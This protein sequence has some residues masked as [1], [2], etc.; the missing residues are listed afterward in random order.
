V[1]SAHG[2]LE[3]PGV[4]AGELVGGFPDTV[5]P[6]VYAVGDVTS[7]ATPK[8][9]VFAEGQAAVVASAIIARRA[10]CKSPVQYG[11]GQVYM[12]FGHCQ[13]GRLDLTFAAGRPPPAPS[14]HPQPT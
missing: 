13:V 8:V 9:G 3:Y 12:E 11:R 1:V 6:G 4:F 14:R 7:V 5:F 10:G 2:G